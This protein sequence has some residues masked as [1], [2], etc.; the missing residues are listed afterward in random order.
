M[1]MRICAF[2]EP[3]EILNIVK[4]SRKG[5]EGCDADDALHRSP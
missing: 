1:Q 3:L 2:A 4:Q 5:R